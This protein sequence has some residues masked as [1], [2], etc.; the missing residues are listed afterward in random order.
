VRRNP[1]AVLIDW[2]TASSQHPEYFGPDGIHIG[3]VGARAYT[4]LI[5]KQLQPLLSADAVR[6]KSTIH[7]EE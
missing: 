2:R 6:K 1:N 7:P 5:V 4:L 3:T